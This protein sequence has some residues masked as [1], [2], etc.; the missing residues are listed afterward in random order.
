M[1][2]TDVLVIGQGLAGSLLAYEL[3]KAGV[4]VTIIDNGSRQTSS[5]VAGGLY[6]PITGRN[7]VKTW[8]ADEV[9]PSLDG[10]YATLQEILGRTFHHPLPI[11]R[12]FFNMEE[13]NDWIGKAAS[14][15]YKAFVNQVHVRSI[16]IDGLLDPF[17]GVEV[18]CS[19]YIDLPEMLDGF[20]SYFRDKGN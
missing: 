11:Y 19:G 12:P 2:H 8:L 10:Y 20:E 9:F 14:D 16:G 3:E 15:T 17:G 6:N 7:M 4:N 5:R 18:K 1:I 13:Q